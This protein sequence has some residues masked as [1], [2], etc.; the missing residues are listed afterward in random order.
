[1]VVFL[2]FG[3]YI[4]QSNLISNKNK[5]KCTNQA[6]IG[7]PLE[8]VNSNNIRLIR[9][10]VIICHKKRALFFALLCKTHANT[11]QVLPVQTGLHRYDK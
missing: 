4:L 3:S 6:A 5:F 11:Q 10:Q 7:K 1:M 2:C 9:L 8:I